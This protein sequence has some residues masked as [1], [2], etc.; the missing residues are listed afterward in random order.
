M[1]FVLGSL[2]L[3]LKSLLVGRAASGDRVRPRLAQTTNHE[4]P[5]T[6][7]SP[8]RNVPGCAPEE[9]ESRSEKGGNSRGRY[10]VGLPPGLFAAASLPR[11]LWANTLRPGNES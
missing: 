7:A 10:V 1:F 3:A 8:V 6:P 11:C 5:T 9:R 2:F 4:P